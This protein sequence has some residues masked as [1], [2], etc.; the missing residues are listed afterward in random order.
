MNMKD[1]PFFKQAQ[2][3]RRRAATA[4]LKAVLEL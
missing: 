2:L 1:S 3:V 4:K